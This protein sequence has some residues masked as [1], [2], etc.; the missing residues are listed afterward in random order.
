MIA[1]SSTA[2]AGYL[3]GVLIKDFEEINALLLF[4]FVREFLIIQEEE[5]VMV[6]AQADMASSE[7]SSS[8]RMKMQRTCS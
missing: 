4:N 5:V 8:K 2:M 7:C 3:G 1:L 6:A